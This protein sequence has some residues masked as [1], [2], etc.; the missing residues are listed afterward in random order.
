[1]KQEK[2]KLAA[3]LKSWLRELLSRSVGLPMGSQANCLS[4]RIPPT[5]PTWEEEN[6]PGCLRINHVINLEHSFLM[7]SGTW[8]Q[9]AN[10]HLSREVRFT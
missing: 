6:W 3:A 9:N 5:E 8:V 4:S 2:P 7:S 1:M 10:Y